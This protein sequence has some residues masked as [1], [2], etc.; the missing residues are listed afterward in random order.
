MSGAPAPRMRAAVQPGYGPPSVVRVD[1]VDRPEPGDGELLVRVRATTVN[2]TDCGYRA[3]RPFLI[4]AVAGVRRP[5][6]PVGGTELA[7]DV[8]AVG[9]DVDR[10]AVGD[11]VFAYVEG[12]FGAHAEYAV[13]P[14]TGS[15]AH[16]PADIT[17]EVAA[18]AT[19]GAHYA[20]SCVRWAKVVPG[21]RVL[22]Y[23]ATGAI[24]SAAV[25]LLRTM[26]V[27]VT[28]VCG[29]DHVELVQGLGPDR[30]V[31]YQTEDFTA[32]EQ[33]YDAVIDA[34]G[35]ITFGRCRHLLVPGGVYVSSE[36]GPYAQNLFLALVTPPLRRRHVRF[37]FPSVDQAMIERLAGLLETG[38]YR[39][40]IDRT[41]PLEE[42]VD[43]YTY[44][45]TGRKLGNVVVRLD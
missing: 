18:P 22:V 20:L 16:I 42:I 29:T 5:R 17:Y 28:A 36:L 10:F 32:D 6:H 38:E 35:K 44:V 37:P 13:V 45:E 34:V 43:A 7:G 41:Y 30:V 21:Q 27:T 31:D 23:G 14:A 39:P 11:R 33:R 1:E 15:I 19:E 12:T 9:A 24:G 26:D 8:V 40:M 3:A 4:R 25:Q 2:R